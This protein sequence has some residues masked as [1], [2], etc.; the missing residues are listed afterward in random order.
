MVV[1]VVVVG[2]VVVQYSTLVTLLSGA[3]GSA[4][5]QLLILETIEKLQPDT[6]MFE[7]AQISD[8][9]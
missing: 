2:V 6:C 9:V 1:V 8:L 3:A 7:P 5:A 4:E